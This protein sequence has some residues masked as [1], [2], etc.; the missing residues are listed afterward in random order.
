VTVRR[1]PIGPWIWTENGLGFDEMAGDPRQRNGQDL[2]RPALI[3]AHGP[4]VEVMLLS[5]L[6]TSMLRATSSS[7][8]WP[9]PQTVHE[10]SYDQTANGGML[11][12]Q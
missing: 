2:R 6:R 7:R 1:D 8:S 12:G 3:V 5:A 10:Y 4:I 9:T 11:S